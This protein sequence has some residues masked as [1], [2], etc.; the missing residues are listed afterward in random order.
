M[1]GLIP[2]KEECKNDDSMLRINGQ[3]E[4][5]I[6]G[7]PFYIERISYTVSTKSMRNF[8]TGLKG[9]A[10]LLKN[11]AS[12]IERYVTNLEENEQP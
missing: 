4:T 1:I 5:S 10:E 6:S 8:S 3:I 11:E 12:E 2:N 9:L 7:D